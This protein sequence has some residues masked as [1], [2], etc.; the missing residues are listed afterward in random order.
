ME[1][2]LTTLMASI[3]GGRRYWVRAPQKAVRPYVILN[4]IDKPRLYTMRGQDALTQSRVQADVYS[5]TY[6]GAK[7]VARSIVNLLSGYRVGQFRGVFV[8][9]ER[10]L[11]AESAGAVN[12][13]FRVSIDLMIH[14]GEQP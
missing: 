10:D 9:S 8:D 3:A 13:L 4:L 12:Q 11:P 7:A 1:E 6:E 14:Y 2:D 5:D